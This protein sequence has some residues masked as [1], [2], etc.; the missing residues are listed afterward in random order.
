MQ[1]FSSITNVATRVNSCP[2]VNV[3]EPHGRLIDADALIYSL[4]ASDEDIYCKYTIEE[5][6]PTVIEAEGE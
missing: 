6:A 2:L 3:P 4:G 5:D 1:M